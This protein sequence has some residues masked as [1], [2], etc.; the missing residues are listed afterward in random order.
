MRRSRASA[1]SSISLPSRRTV[2]GTV[3][4]G[5]IIVSSSLDYAFFDGGSG[6]IGG[7]RGLVKDGSGTLTINNW[8][9][10]SGVTLVNNGTLVLNKSSW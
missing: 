8:N 9:T 7:T 3:V 10:Y 2:I 5:S 4:P 1:L 6:K